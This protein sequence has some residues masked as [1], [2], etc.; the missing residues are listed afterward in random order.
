MA[1]GQRGKNHPFFR[2]IQRTPEVVAHR[3]GGGEWPG[4]TIYAFEE[5][6]K[7]GFDILEMDIRATS[8]ED[9]IL[10]HNSNVLETTGVNGNVKKLTSAAI[11]K[12]DAA[13]SWR[14]AGAVFPPGAKLTVPRLEDVFL[15]FPG[16]RMNI[17]I[18][19]FFFPR[20]LVKQLCELIRKYDMT[21]KVLIASAWHRHLVLLRRLCPEIATSASLLEMFCFRV[22]KSVGYQPN[23]DAIQISSKA[24]PFHFITQKYVNKVHRINLIV[25]GWTVNEPEEMKRLISL[26]VDGIITDYPTRLMKL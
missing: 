17:E 18:K 10:M 8:D 14:K 7:L 24:G 16:V 19:P 6:R 12:L 11:Q 4:E 5:A 15:N 25:H 23:A 2:G 9:L 20:R 13:F 26:G 3:G 1:A 21:E 22:L